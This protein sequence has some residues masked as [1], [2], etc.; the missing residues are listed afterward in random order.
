MV[1]GLA[2]SAAFAPSLHARILDRVVASVGGQ[3]I[4]ASDVETEYRF[5]RFME[6]L[7]PTGKP[8]APARG[9]ILNR[10]ISRMLLQDDMRNSG[11][12][13]KPSEAD[14]RR[15]LRQIRQRFHSTAQYRSAVKSLGMGEAEV[16]KRLE[17]YQ[18][19]L[20]YVDRRFRPVTPPTA[21]EI[22]VFYGST[23]LPQFQKHH[24]HQ[25]PPPLVKVESPIQ[26]ILF[27]K[28]LDQRLNEWLKEMRSTERVRII[29]N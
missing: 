15:A 14:A 11:A 17:V 8:A 7:V 5:E 13:I 2:L 16:L 19:T 22:R 25:P 23:F 26:E 6:G 12:G 18:E 1:C 24:P 10:L 21:A 27:Q 28:E 9:V 20:R 29:R 3:A 4:T